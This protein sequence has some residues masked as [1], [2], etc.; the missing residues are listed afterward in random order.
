MLKKDEKKLVWNEV[1]GNDEEYDGIS[2]WQF[3]EAA[4]DTGAEEE[5]V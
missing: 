3:E 1:F 2:L 5:F 4:R